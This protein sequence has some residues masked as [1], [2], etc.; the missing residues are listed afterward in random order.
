MARTKIESFRDLFI[1]E[2]KDLY[3]AE[4]QLLTALPKM[5][6]AASSE[7]LINA[8]HA[9]L[10]ETRKQKQ[11]L[12]K[13]S[14]LLDVDLKG[15]SC[16]A[17]KGLVTEGE[18]TI[19]LKTHDSIRDA[20]LIAAA[21]RVEHYEIAGYGTAVHYADILQE[22]EI[23]DLLSETLSEEKSTDEKLNRIAKQHVNVK[24]EAV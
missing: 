17:M 20:A 16:E 6:E 8:F 9:H 18:E 14:E 13:I 2:L 11:R 21:Q 4:K 22:A 15:E 19:K 5:A 23:S 1:H 12:E 3:D 24:A 7:K 10:E